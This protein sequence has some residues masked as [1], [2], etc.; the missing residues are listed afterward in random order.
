MSL[1]PS[2]VFISMSVPR[3]YVQKWAPWAM[4][5]SRN[6]WPWTRLPI[7]RPCMSVNATTIVSTVP[8]RTRPSSSAR[9]GCLVACSAAW[10]WSLIA[11]LRV[12]GCRA[13]SV[14]ASYVRG[15]VETSLLGRHPAIRDQHRA[16]DERRLVRGKEQGGVRDLARL[17]GA[18]DRLERVDLGVDIVETAEHL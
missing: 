12:N 3:R 11:L 4:T 1:K 8:S 10:P 7:S 13:P 2:G 17:T 9:R 5:P 6:A 18:P 15:A 14:G 16:R